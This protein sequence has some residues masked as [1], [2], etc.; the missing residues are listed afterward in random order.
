MRFCCLIV[1]GLVACGDGNSENSPSTPTAIGLEVAG[2]W[3]SPYGV[4]TISDTAWG[5]DAFSGHVVKFDNATN[6]AVVQGPQKGPHEPGT[7]SKYVWTDIKDNVFY[8]CTVDY[9]LASLAAVAAS[10][11]VADASDPDHKGCGGFAWTKLTRQ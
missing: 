5:S 8:Y 9:N 1:L 11:K 4:E 2:T 3:T 7:Y 10:T 6:V